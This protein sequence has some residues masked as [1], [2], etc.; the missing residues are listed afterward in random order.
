[1]QLFGGMWKIIRLPLQNISKLTHYGSNELCTV[2]I[3]LVNRVVQCLFK[4]RCMCFLR[5]ISTREC[6]G[7]ESRAFAFLSA[8]RMVA[9]LEACW[10]LNLLL[11]Y[12]A[13]CC[14][15]PGCIATRRRRHSLKMFCFSLTVSAWTQLHDWWEDLGWILYGAR[16]RYMDR[17]CTI[18]KFWRVRRGRVTDMSCFRMRRSEKV[19]RV[20]N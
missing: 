18:L 4:T 1:M 19:T 11:A 17:N 9:W 10:R 3:S 2:G 16:P 6:D 8:E 13:S 15:I 5:F 20:S 12:C 7:S 14:W